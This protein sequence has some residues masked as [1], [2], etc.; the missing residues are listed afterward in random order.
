MEQTFFDKV[1]ECLKNGAVLAKNGEYSMRAFLNGKMSLSAAEGMID[2]IN[3]ESESEVVAGYNLMDGNLTKQVEK[4]QKELVDI[5]GEVE[6]SFDYPEEDIEYTTSK[7]IKKRLAVLND[8]I[9]TLI[10]SS[11][12]GNIIKNGINAVIVGRPNVG[13]SSLLN[14]L[15][16]KDKAIVTEIAGTTRDIIEDAFEI[17]GVK[18]NIIDTAGIHNTTDKIE[19][20]GVNKSLDYINKA[21]IVLFVLD[22]LE[23]NLLVEF[24]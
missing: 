18:V 1:E 16:N 13:K 22:G 21:D 11:S 10:D 5:M 20:I 2:L 17:N 23:S 6:V 9:K 4:F 14:A 19:K 15:I 8:N 12:T 3:A 7:I 24:E